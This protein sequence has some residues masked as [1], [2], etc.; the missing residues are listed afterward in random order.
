MIVRDEGD[1]PPLYPSQSRSKTI[2]GSLMSAFQPYPLTS[3]EV[4]DPH[5]ESNR[6]LDSKSGVSRALGPISSS[7]N[8]Q[9][10]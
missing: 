1:G 7:D 5:Y 8:N 9:S 4:R 10:L 6:Q 3:S 2:S